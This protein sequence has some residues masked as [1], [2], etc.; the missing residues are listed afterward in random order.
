MEDYCETS[1]A[2]TCR[3]F[4]LRRV[5]S[6]YSRSI[7]IRINLANAWRSRASFRSNVESFIRE[8]TFCQFFTE[9]QILIVNQFSIRHRHTGLKRKE[10][11]K[12]I[13]A[14]RE[15]SLYAKDSRGFDPLEG[16]PKGSPALL[17]RVRS[18]TRPARLVARTARP[19]RRSWG[20]AFSPRVRC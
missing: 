13:K 1:P 2:K 7:N 11:T 9:R 16:L 19:P 5:Y 3:F 10:K 18:R 8:Q 12:S 4:F 17:P 14:Q 15:R 20:A 6:I